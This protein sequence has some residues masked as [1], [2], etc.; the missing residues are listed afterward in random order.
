[1]DCP[2]DAPVRTQKT[3]EEKDFGT[4]F[5]IRGITGCGKTFLANILKTRLEARGKKVAIIEA[6][7]N[8]K[9]GT[10]NVRN[11]SSSRI[12]SAHTEK[13]MELRTRL[14]AGF[15]CIISNCSLTA[16]DIKSYTNSDHLINIR[17]VRRKVCQNTKITILHME[18]VEFPGAHHID[19]ST[20]ERYKRNFMDKRFFA[21]QDLTEISTCPQQI[22]QFCQVYY[23]K[24]RKAIF[25]ARPGCCA[26]HGSEYFEP[27]Y[28]IM[29]E[30]DL[31]ENALAKYILLSRMCHK[32]VAKLIMRTISLFVQWN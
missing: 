32:D 3:L 30:Y 29:Q 10:N 11:Y 25:F 8:M 31:K 13:Q 1:M 14:E 20:R 12:R 16:Q 9:T 27:N 21:S 2:F 6:N 24:Q 15:V 22:K 5:I 4:I 17:G 28:T 18:P 7:D 26:I 19:Q 23:C